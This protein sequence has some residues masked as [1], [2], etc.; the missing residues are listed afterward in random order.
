MRA[1]VCAQLRYKATAKIV[2]A[3]AHGDSLE[4]LPDSVGLAAKPSDASDVQLLDD[5]IVFYDIMERE[6]SEPCPRS[7]CV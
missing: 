2:P 4:E 3:S 5:D 1:C 6:V 7:P